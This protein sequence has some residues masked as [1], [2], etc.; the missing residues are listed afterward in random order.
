MKAL[1]ISREDLV[2]H[3]PIS[4]NLDFKRHAYWRLFRAND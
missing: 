3:T 2:R 4:G 1:F